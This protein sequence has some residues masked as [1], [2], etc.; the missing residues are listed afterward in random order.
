M[1]GGTAP[2]IYSWSNGAASKDISNLSAG[3]Y[4]VSITDANKNICVLKA[5]VIEECAMSISYISNPIKC[6]G[7]ENGAI[8]ISVTGGKAPYKFLWNNGATTEDISGLLP[9]TYNLT[10]TDANGCSIK[11]SYTIDIVNSFTATI[12]KEVCNPG[13]LEAN[14][15]GGQGPYTYFWSNVATTKEVA[16]LIDGTYSVIISDSRGCSITKN[17]TLSGNHSPLVLKYILMKPSCNNPSGGGIDLQV[18][19]GKAPYTFIW[20]NG[21]TSEDLADLT[22]GNYSVTVADAKG[23]FESAEIILESPA[24]MEIYTTR[25]SRISCFGNTDGELEI[26]VTGGTAPYSYLWSNGATTLKINNLPAGQYEVIVSDAAG[27]KKVS[28]FLIAEPLKLNAFIV[29][30]DCNDGSVDLVVS[31]GTRPYTYLWSNGAIT[32]D[33]TGLE[34]GDY[35]VVVTDSRGCVVEAEITIT[36]VVDPIVVK[37]ETE[38]PKCNGGTGSAHLSVSGG[39]AP[40]SYTWSNGAGTENISDLK[41]GIYSVKVTDANA[42][43]KTLTFT[44]QSPA[45]I[46]I[47]AATSS[48]I[49]CFGEEDGF[50]NLQVEGGTLPYSFKWSNGKTSK[51]LSDLAAG[52]YK[53]L[54][55]DANGCSKEASFTITQPEELEAGITAN[56]CNN[57]LLDLVVTGGSKPYQYSWSNGSKTEDLTSFS[58]GMYY[59][60]VTDAKGCTVV[61][62]IEVAKPEIIKLSFETQASGCKCGSNGAINLTVEGGTGPY[63]YLWSDGKISED[64]SDIAAGEYSIVVTGFKR[65]FSVWISYNRGKSCYCS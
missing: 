3:L 52:A 56:I 17:A 18:T 45:A 13:Y 30:E 25:F 64:I 43:F 10:V 29:N 28:T 44:I 54:V 14:A 40:Y 19:G 35:S 50:L 48:N 39:T 38:N 8:D 31:G 4:S 62:G 21:A 65:L 9:G 47:Q 7:D 60:E 33:L 26:L 6:F 42:C 59:V 32:E 58:E 22:A 63:T 27:C 57:P 61:A 36:E 15:E 2:F 34:T 12:E 1:S 51:D 23:C 53:V 16:G 5:E 41:A 46:Q 37:L 24:Q 11:E 20:S 49:S 55:T